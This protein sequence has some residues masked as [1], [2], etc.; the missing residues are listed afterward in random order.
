MY[1]NESESHETA[2]ADS[3]FAQTLRNY[4]IEKQQ[5]DGS[6]SD[7]L[8]ALKSVADDA[9]KRHEKWPKDS[10]SLSQELRERAPNLRAV[11]I[12]VEFHDKARP[13]RIT[14][15][16]TQS[17][18]DAAAATAEWVAK[19]TQ[20]A[21]QPPQPVQVEVDGQPYMG[22]PQTPCYGSDLYEETLAQAALPK[23]VRF[24]S[25]ASAKPVAPVAMPP[26]N[27][28]FCDGAQVPCL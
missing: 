6:S 19:A 21:Q 8:K 26:L 28:V 13:K 15:K 20:I 16:L 5:F 7:L 25:A 18:D 17:S 23:L 4:I 10:R 14:L 27:P 11:G 3:P 9:A 2:I 24:W 1:R 22:T 12:D